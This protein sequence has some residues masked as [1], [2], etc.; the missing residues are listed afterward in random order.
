MSE[1]SSSF[2][3]FAGRLLDYEGVLV[4]RIEPEGLE[5]LAPAPVAQVLQIPELARLGF[6]ADLP[7]NSERVGLESDWLERFGLL[8]GERGQT[9]RVTLPVALPQLTNAERVV[10]H[11]VNL[12]NAVYRVVGVTPAWT[13]YL[14]MLFRVT[15]F[16]DEKRDSVI[17]LGFNLANGSALDA[18]ADELLSSAI[19]MAGLQDAPPAP[20]GLP[21]DWT[22]AQLQSRVARAL[23][24]RIEAHLA[25]FLKG[26]QR[27]LNRDLWRVHDYFNELRAESLLRLRKHLAAEKESTRER[28]RLEAIAREYEAKVADLRQKY[29][30]RVDV[31][32]S[33]TLEVV[34]P[35]QRIA[36]LIRRRKGERRIAL[37]WNPLARK[38]DV[39]PCEHS[40]TQ[41][42]VRVVCDDRLHLTSLAAQGPCAG[43][44]RA[45]CRA[46]HPLQC[47]KCRREE[48]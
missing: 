6:A 20:A 21:P 4:E 3:D 13:R 2:R 26:M 23:P 14:V 34:M 18:I 7:A 1:S 37:D 36:I 12:Q 42:P 11:T 47:P 8:L 28:L 39:P 45:F 46:C 31:T 48:G 10:E 17:K 33:Q 16:S 22:P 19:E 32:W 41:S 44:E 27:R 9:A 30:L 15:A 25:P 24:E 38:L 40:Y 29:A 43:C 5:L 35:V